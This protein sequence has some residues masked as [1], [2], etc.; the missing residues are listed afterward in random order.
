M[1]QFDGRL[2]GVRGSGDRNLYHQR[3]L[4]SG[5]TAVKH[6]NTPEASSGPQTTSREDLSLTGRVKSLE[7]QKF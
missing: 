2:T 5:K 7:V 6:P 4:V 1:K 3:P